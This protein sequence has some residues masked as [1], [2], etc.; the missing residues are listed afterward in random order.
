M[1]WRDLTST[2][3][4]P[5]YNKPLSQ[6]SLDDQRLQG[7]ERDGPPEARLKFGSV[8]LLSV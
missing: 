2:H 7:L 8:L 5:K 4:M 3:A 6:F 1:Q